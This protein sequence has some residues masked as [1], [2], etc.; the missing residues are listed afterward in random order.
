MYGVYGVWYI[1]DDERPSLSAVMKISHF[2]IEYFIFSKFYYSDGD[3]GDDDDGDGVI[4]VVVFDV[5]AVGVWH[6]MC[7]TVMHHHTKQLVQRY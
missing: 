7:F 2:D 1:C 3:G 6:F 4:G 5:V